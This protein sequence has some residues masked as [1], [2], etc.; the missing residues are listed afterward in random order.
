MR[1]VD[2]YPGVIGGPCTND[3]HDGGRG[4]S[5]ARPW[6]RETYF[7]QRL[8]VAALLIMVPWLQSACAGERVVFGNIP[9]STFQFQTLI[10]HNSGGPSGWH[11]A[12]VLILL[13]RL[14]T[15]FPR[16][17]TCDVEVGVPL[18]NFE[19]PVTVE[20]AQQ[21]SAT[22]ADRA[23]R[24]ILTQRERP[25]ASICELFRK[26]MRHILGDRDTGLI[27]GARV[28]KFWHPNIP[29]TTFPRR[30]GRSPQ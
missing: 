13:G 5:L 8:C 28:R 19:G 22:A 20:M 30:R 24:E 26:T 21:A 7:L 6:P 14:S 23:A 25:T 17:A 10:E 11:I 29:R 3:S 2:R 1:P 27:K 16:A 12:Q 15:M 18:E 4:Q 9:P